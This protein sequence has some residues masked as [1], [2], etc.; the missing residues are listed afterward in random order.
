MSKRLCFG[1]ILVHVWCMCISIIFEQTEWCW[2]AYWGFIGRGYKTWLVKQ[3]DILES[4]HWCLTHRFCNLLSTP[5]DKIPREASWFLCSNN[6]PEVPI[7]KKIQV[8]WQVLEMR[9][10]PCLS[11]KVSKFHNY[12]DQEKMH[13][14]V[15]QRLRKVYWVKKKSKTKQLQCNLFLYQV[16]CCFHIASDLWW[17]CVY[18]MF[19]SCLTIKAFLKMISC[20]E[21]FCALYAHAE[22]LEVISPHWQCRC[23]E[24]ERIATV[25]ATWR[26]HVPTRS[27]VNSGQGGGSEQWAKVYAP[28]CDKPATHLGSD[29]IQV[30]EVFILLNLL[31]VFITGI[32]VNLLTLIKV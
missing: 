26:H 3:E 20:C 25:G 8:Q 16:W 18:H 22:W 30:L 4:C 13:I 7:Q 19:P 28:R 12:F 23:M 14:C 17:S 1:D 10:C 29:L 21:E 27:K 24:N 31:Q 5:K 32:K 2:E 15:Q 6:V 11:F 9:K